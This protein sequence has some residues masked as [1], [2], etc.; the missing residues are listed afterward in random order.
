MGRMRPHRAGHLSGP[1]APTLQDVARVAGV[2]TATISR[3]LNHAQMVTARTRSRVDLAIAQTGYLPNRLA[4]GLAS[5][6]SRLVAALVPSIATSMFNETIEAMSLALAAAGYQVVLGITG[7]DS[8]GMND[9]VTSLLSHRPD[10]LILTSAPADQA[11]R[12]RLRGA[13]VTVIE[14]WDLPRTPVDLAIGFSHRRAGHALAE[15]VMNRGYRRP[16]LLTHALARGRARMEGFLEYW[17]GHKLA[18]P[19]CDISPLAPFA[20]DGRERLA[21][22]LDGGGRADV[23]VCSSDRLAA[24]VLAEA[25]ARGFRVPVDLAVI[26]FG[27]SDSAALAVPALTSVRID[28]AMIGRRAAEVLILRAQGHKP[29]SRLIDIG[30]EILQRDT[31]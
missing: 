14:T 1:G 9:A 17:E 21:R 16:L 5:K 12:R 4:G 10:A 6:R 28:G 13:R 26:G 25:Q 2:S 18:Q 19:V 7:Y 11:I 24:M 15:F 31:A 3:A 23:V 8:K 27:A 30:F 20:I 29:A 22:F